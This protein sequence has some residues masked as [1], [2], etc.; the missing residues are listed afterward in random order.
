MYKM[1]SEKLEVFIIENVWKNCFLELFEDNS[2][3]KL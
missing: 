2:S 3:F 1:L